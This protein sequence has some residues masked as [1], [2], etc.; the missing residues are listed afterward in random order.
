MPKKEVWRHGGTSLQSGVPG[1]YL[2]AATPSDPG[3][4][5]NGLRGFCI[6]ERVSTRGPVPVLG[7]VAL[8]GVD[9]FFGDFAFF[10]SFPDFFESGFVP[11]SDLSSALGFS[12]DVRSAPEVGLEES[13]TRSSSPVEGAD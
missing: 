7:D 5:R 1:P 10:P 9:G 3:G 2:S 11:F 4:S 13:L 12:A 8:A 6:S